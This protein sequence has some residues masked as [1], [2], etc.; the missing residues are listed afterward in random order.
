MATQSIST[1]E[2]MPGSFTHQRYG[3]EREV[4]RALRKSGAP[5]GEVLGRAATLGCWV[6][7][8]IV[9]GQRQSFLDKARDQMAQVV[10]RF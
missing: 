3:N 8:G 6:L 5:R 7:D 1:T 10:F 4:G 9:Q 2:N